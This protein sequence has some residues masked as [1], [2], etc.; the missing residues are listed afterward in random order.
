MATIASV[1]IS[2]DSIAA[3]AAAHAPTI[4]AI[5]GRSQTRNAAINESMMKK[6][7]SRSK[8]ADHHNDVPVIA[9]C[10]ANNS[11]TAAA[12][13][14]RTDARIRKRHNNSAVAM[15]NPVSNTACGA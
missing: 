7:A 6:V 8:R 12:T 9:G 15:C 2:F 3:M 5:D 1:P 4:R 13:A 10:K 11:T 14:G